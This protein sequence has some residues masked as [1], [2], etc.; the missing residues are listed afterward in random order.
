M[1]GQKLSTLEDKIDPRVAALL[2]IDMLNEF[3]SPGGA[4]DRTGEEQKALSNII[5]LIARGREY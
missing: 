5:N 3:V 1:A 4:W 2:V